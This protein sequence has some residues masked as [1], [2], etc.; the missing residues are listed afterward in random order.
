MATNKTITFATA[1]K[2]DMECYGKEVNFNRA[3]VDIS[4]LKRV[5][6]RIL[7]MMYKNGHL[8]NK[9]YAK[10]PDIVGDVIKLH[11]H[12]D[13][14]I[15]DA[16]VRLAQ[17]W[18]LNYPLIDFDGSVGS[19]D[20]DRAAAARYT[21]ARLSEYGLAL[22]RGI[23]NTSPFVADYAD[24]GVEPEYLVPA[25]PSLLVNISKGIGVAAAC[26]FLPHT[27]EDIY[28]AIDARMKGASEDDIASALH[29]TFPTGGILMNGADLPTIY[30]T[31]RGSVKLRAKHKIDG[32]KIIFTELPYQVSR[33]SVIEV[34]QERKDARI[35]SIYDTSDKFQKSITIETRASDKEAFAEELFKTTRLEDTFNINMTIHNRRK[36][37]L[38]SFVSLIDEYIACQHERIIS[39]AT[40]ARRV[41]ETKKHE[42]E[43]FVVVLPNIDRV[44]E[45]IKDSDDNKAANAQL[46]DEFGISFEQAKAILGIRLSQLTKRGIDDTKEEIQSLDETILEQLELENDS[47][48]RDTKLLSEIA[49]LP[50][51]KMKYKMEIQ[52]GSTP[53]MTYT[54][55]TIVATNG[56]QLEIGDTDELVVITTEGRGYRF[57]GKQL[58]K[59]PKDEVVLMHTPEWVAEQP[60]VELF[61]RKMDPSV[62]LV[63]CKSTRGAKLKM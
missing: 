10:C 42:L 48:K 20:N 12:A 59:L 15:Y 8:P 21:G 6:L 29:P 16:L 7:Y 3:I 22:I 53:Q 2:E 45:I 34:L 13:T 9:K 19:E 24:E 40:A 46:M 11:P 25:F 63:Q 27:I 30:K 18:T 33:T 60:F 49:D 51:Q 44:I 54:E 32:N 52:M 55:H 5:Q 41:A 4:G 56:D 37:E 28:L 1:M 23:E 36:V 39:L 31:G 61:G 57:K 50:K 35:I 17:P 62:L 43:G 58:D 38:R 26:N 14:A 47:H